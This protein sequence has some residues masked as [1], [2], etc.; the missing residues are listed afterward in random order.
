MKN[1]AEQGQEIDESESRI[2]ISQATFVGSS[3]VI[4]TGTIHTTFLVEKI[5]FP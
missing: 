1:H 3:H 2:D 5:S 4:S